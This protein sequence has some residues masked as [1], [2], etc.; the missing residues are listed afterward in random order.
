MLIQLHSSSDVF[1]PLLMLIGLY[2][3]IGGGAPERIAGSAFYIATFF[4]VELAS[5]LAPRFSIMEAGIFLVDVML[6]ACLVVLMLKANR[7]WTIWICSMQAI[8]VLSHLPMLFIPDLIPLA[9]RVVIS[10]WAYPML[11]LLAIGTWRHRDRL[12]RYGTDRPW[13]SYSHR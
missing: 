3:I 1:V 2:A 13:S 5:R 4:S 11:T 8:T 12:Q 10:I 9:Y 6:L 7:F